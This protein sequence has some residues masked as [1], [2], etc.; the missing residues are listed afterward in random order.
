M[1]CTDEPTPASVCNLRCGGTVKPELAPPVLGENNAD[2]ERRRGCLAPKDVGMTNGAAAVL[3]EATFGA[4]T[5][6]LP[7]DIVPG[8]A[9]AWILKF[10]IDDVHG[11]EPWLYFINNHQHGPHWSF[12][13]SIGCDTDYPENRV[14]GEL[15]YRPTAVGPNGAIGT[16]LFDNSATDGPLPF[17]TVDAVHTL[18][19]GGMPALA[20]N[21]GYLPL[22][23]DQQEKVASEDELYDNAPFE[24]HVVSQLSVEDGFLALNRGQTFGRLRVIALDEVPSPQDLVIYDALP[25]ELPSVAGIITSVPQTPLSHVN[26]RAIQDGVP[27]AFIE[28]G[29]NHASIAPLVGAYVF[30]QVT[31]TGFDIREATPVEVEAY[32]GDFRPSDVQLPSRDLSV[33]NIMALEQLGFEDA[34][35]FGAK[36]SNLAEMHGFGLP[37]GLLP[38]GLAVPFSFYDAFMTH[39]GFYKALDDLETTLAMT[40][41]R[42]E[43]GKLLAGL[44]DAIKAGEMPPWMTDALSVAQASFP[45]GTSIRCRSSTNNEDL[46]G[47]SGAGLYES[48]THHP[49]EGHLSK[50]I[51]QVYAGMWTLRAFESRE[52]HR[53]DHRVAAMG[54]L[55]H[56]NYSGETVNGVAMS[57][58]VLYGFGEDLFY[59]NSQVGEALVT[60]PPPDS[61]PEEMGIFRGAD[62]YHT[63]RFSSLVD[64]DVNLLN[65]EQVFALRD[66]L[67]T[68]HERFESLYAT[69]EDA[70]FLMEV[71]FK[72]TAAG[73][74][75]IKQARPWV[76]NRTVAQWSDDACSCRC[77]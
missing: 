4:L 10:V 65:E 66:S 42:A 69:A 61:K 64:G 36:A 76:F 41:D 71:E 33:K 14:V 12:T 74:L 43:R 46:P 56:P 70:P 5:I 55:M 24:T 60:N 73:N 62:E 8:F 9:D 37:E 2:G 54:I 63:F 23:I 13:Q 67:R 58:D 16:Y 20:D 34:A 68:I 21:L 40:S 72:I 57:G 59:V 44:R 29:A 27:N 26:L 7:S 22:S 19:I 18:L 47:Y 48:Y 39:N 3:D 31:S 38:E 52:F 28:T 17:G 1:I 35:A 30:Y 15:F 25:N 6:P 50:S 11:P 77:P 32:F 53:I 45:A 49:H 51:R 75:A